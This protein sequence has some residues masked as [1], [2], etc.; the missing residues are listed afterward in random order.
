MNRHHAALLAAMLVGLSAH[1]Q[2][3]ALSACTA[4]HMTM[5]LDDGQGAFNGMM[6]SGTWLVLRN[7][8]ARA[9]SLASMGSLSF[10]DGRNH[11]IPVTWQQAVPPPAIA[12][13]AGGEVTTALRWVSGDVF[14]P[15][16]CITPATLVL[17]LRHGRVRH[18]FAHAL[19]APAQ[20]P[21]MLEQQPWTVGPPGQG[22]AH[23]SFPEPEAHP[24]S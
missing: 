2:A 3:R 18:A 12:L 24:H 20:R 21:P 13:P 19:C 22:Q 17:T 1:A 7:K 8:G 16:T 4:R 10:E 23:G 6:H 14:D 15:G 9:C 5:T 11:S